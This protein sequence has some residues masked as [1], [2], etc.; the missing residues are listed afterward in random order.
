MKSSVNYRPVSVLIVGLALAGWW[1]F[2]V[3]VARAEGPIPLADYRRMVEQSL[4]LVEQA[5]A[6]PIASQRQALLQQA[7][8]LLGEVREVQLDSGERMS[9]NNEPLLAQMRDTTQSLQGVRDLRARLQALRDAL[10][11]APGPINP[12]DLPKLRELLNRPPFKQEVVDNWFT[13]L[14]NDLFRLLLRSAAT[15]IVDMRGLITLLGIVLVTLVLIYFVRNLAISTAAEA[16]LQTAEADDEAHQTPS[17]ALS[18]AQRL[19]SAGDYRAAVRQ[20]YLSTLLL[21]DERGRLRYDRSLTN[22]EYL[23]AVSTMPTIAAALKPIV[24]TFD[25][26]WYGFAPINASEFEQYRRQV[27]AIREM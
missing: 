13:R 19:A 6:Q 15:G 21:L 9:V 4:A 8:S 27:E 23:R 16:T 1:A 14:I 18:H 20:L 10:A 5:V 3:Q 22:H 17:S 25:R 11:E 12:D 2:A 24:E 7:A 26:I